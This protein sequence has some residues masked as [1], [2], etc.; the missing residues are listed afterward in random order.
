[1]KKLFS[2]VTLTMI[3]LTGCGFHLQ[4]E[5]EIPKQFETMTFYSENPYSELS[6]TVKDLLNKNKVLLVQE[7]SAH[8]YP[9]L[10]I[11]NSNIGKET[12]SIYQ[13]GKSAEYQLILTVNAQVIM[14]GRDI[15]PIT[16]KVFR[17]F[18]DN[19]ATALAKTTE[20][21]LIEREMYTQA[22]K[23]LISKLK[24]IN[25]IENKHNT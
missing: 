18:F 23:Q 3:L 15:Y 12:I 8:Q 10:R 5:T 16:T 7:D 21:K 17:T 4:H 14:A 25:T 13:N 24:S 20:Q 2:L 9:S 11:I 1:M 6:R 19:P 22:A